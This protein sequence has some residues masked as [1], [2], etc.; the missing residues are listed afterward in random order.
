[1]SSSS[2]QSLPESNNM[3]SIHPT[4]PRWFAIRTRSKSEKYVCSLLVRKGLNAYIPIQRLMKRYSRS[5]KMTEKPLINSYVF[6]KIVKTEYLRV[7]E[8]EYV[9]GFVHFNRTLI[10]IPESEIDLLRRFTLEPGLDIQAFD[11]KLEIGDPVRISAGGMM[12]ME[13]RIVE[14]RG[15]KYFQVEL[16]TLGKFFRI[17][18]DKN[19]LDKIGHIG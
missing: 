4:E 16:S 10:A 1:M 8:T 11:G 15:K 18:V 2:I 6:V 17:A 7:L 13:G 19:F 3:L 5:T 9:S 14:M 12:G